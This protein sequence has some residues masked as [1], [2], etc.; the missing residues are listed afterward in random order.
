MGE[1]SPMRVAGGTDVTRRGEGKGWL[2]EPL[3]S[4][5]GV[6]NAR[7]ASVASGVGVGWAGALEQA[8]I[9]ASPLDRSKNRWMRQAGIIR[10]FPQKKKLGPGVAPCL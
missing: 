2:G 3:D 4:S 6:G 10:P 8:G 5:F 1:L 9:W 7:G